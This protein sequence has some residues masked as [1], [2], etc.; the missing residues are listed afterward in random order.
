MAIWLVYVP[1]GLFYIVLGGRQPIYSKVLVLNR[2]G[3]DRVL[4]LL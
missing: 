3:S 2:D 1:C 4:V